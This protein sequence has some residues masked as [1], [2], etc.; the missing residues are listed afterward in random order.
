[1]RRQPNS[2]LE[3]APDLES[4][5]STHGARGGTRRKLGWPALLTGLIMVAIGVIVFIR[6][7]SVLALLGTVIAMR[8]VVNLIKYLS[9]NELKGF[10]LF[11]YLGVS[12]LL[13]AIGVVFLIQ[14]PFATLIFYYVTAV[15]FM[16]EG[17]ANY[18]QAGQ[19]RQANLVLFYLVLGLNTLLFIGSV[20]LLF[21]SK[22]PADSARFIN[23]IIGGGLILSGVIY[24]LFGLAGS[25]R[26]PKGTIS[27]SKEI[28][29]QDRR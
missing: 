6:P 25:N 8:G 29:E 5:R 9:F 4:S 28:D 2:E 17:I 1:M 20:V 27:L 26:T 14:P 21:N 19:V 23:I 12:F 16:L 10:R 15:W 11:A 7:E 13:L 22:F 18:M 3:Q 24:F